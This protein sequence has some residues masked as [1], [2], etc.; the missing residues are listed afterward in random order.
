MHSLTFACNNSIISTSLS[1]QLTP[2]ENEQNVQFHN[3]T[4]ENEYQ[5]SCGNHHTKHQQFIHINMELKS[6]GSYTTM[7]H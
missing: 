3:S 1:P 5:S 4:N 2:Q 6:T 7:E